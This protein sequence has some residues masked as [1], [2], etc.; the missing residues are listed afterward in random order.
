MSNCFKSQILL[1]YYTSQYQR[2][3]FI[4]YLPY[5]KHFQTEPSFLTAR[6]IIIIHHYL[7][8]KSLVCL[9]EKKKKIE[10][11]YNYIP[12]LQN[13]CGH[14]WETKSLGSWG[15]WERR[16]LSP[17]TLWKK[18]SSNAGKCF[19]AP[20]AR[21]LITGS[22]LFEGSRRSNKN[23]MMEGNGRRL[24]PQER[25]RPTSLNER[26]ESFFNT[27]A[28]MGYSSITTWTLFQFHCFH[29]IFILFFFH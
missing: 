25:G 29:F 7:H 21:P 28:W 5:A 26:V 18:L 13:R 14:P 27:N 19:E 6:L 10:F 4:F 17:G 1:H 15:E 22:G 2:L 8:H 16:A 20:G 9:K 23:A 24:V 12:Y 3:L 11:T